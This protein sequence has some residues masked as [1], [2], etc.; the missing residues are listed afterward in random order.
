[1]TG[2]IVV[3]EED[4]VFFYFVPRKEQKYLSNGILV[5]TTEGKTL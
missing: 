3:Y 2:N 4:A 1:M 5:G